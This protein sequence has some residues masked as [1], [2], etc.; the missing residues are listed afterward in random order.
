MNFFVKTNW[1]SPRLT[2]RRCFPTPITWSCTSVSWSASE[3]VASGPF[4]NSFAFYL[5]ALWTRITWRIDRRFKVASILTTI[6]RPRACLFVFAFLIF[7]LLI[8]NLFHYTVLFRFAFIQMLGMFW[9]M[10]YK[11][12]KHFFGVWTL[13][14]KAEESIRAANVASSLEFRGHG[15]GR[16]GGGTTKRKKSALLPKLRHG[17]LKRGQVRLFFFFNGWGAL[18]MSFLPQNKLS[19]LFVF[20]LHVFV[21]GMDLYASV[22]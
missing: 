6:G 17:A 3:F 4:L 21:G 2:L 5:F 8:S 10:L 9:K 20:L 12:N 1:S 15:R 13:Q 18:G 11:T 22:C 7:V 14:A 16:G 19:Q